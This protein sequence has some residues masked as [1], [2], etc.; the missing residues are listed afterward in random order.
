[1]A[2]ALLAG[3]A[4]WWYRRT[5][6]SAPSV[7]AS[8]G[9]ADA[10]VSMP[11]QEADPAAADVPDGRDLLGRLYALA[12]DEAD[13][14][15][16]PTPAQAA[17][18]EAIASACANLLGRARFNARYLP[19]R[20]Q[21]LPKLMQAIND[22]DAS[23]EQ[24]A[25][26]IGEDPTLSANLLRIANSPYY[27]VQDKPV[28]SL[29]RAASLLGLE[30]LRPVIATALM[31]PVMQTG[32][33]VFGRLPVVIWEHTQMA[34]A[35]ASALIRGAHRQDDAFA[36]QMLGL[37]HG[38][39]AIIVAQVLRDNHA[40]YPHLRPDP[41]MV[42]R[43]LDGQSA[44]MAHRIATSWELSER[45]GVALDAQKMETVPADALGRALCIGRVAAALAMLCR[46]GKLDAGEGRA[47]LE[48]WLGAHAIDEDLSGIWERLLA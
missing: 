41:R 22:P 32:D 20:P 2:L 17:D 1:M 37:L 45:I 27:R 13:I 29:M 16:V 26:I 3:V 30:G 44:A 40:L 46:H 36:A 34:A 39:G 8:V 43:V 11:P 42:A 7:I 35:C 23:L 48:A 15:A 28:E 33:S 38:L 25:R 14:D 18:Y 5:R 19:R 4:V 47:L 9:I 6:R 21:L 12:F 31:Q 10:V 24:V